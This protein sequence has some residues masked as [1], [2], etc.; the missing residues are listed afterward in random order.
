MLCGLTNALMNSKRRSPHW[1]WS[2]HHEHVQQSLALLC[3]QVVLGMKLE[4]LD[5]VGRE[6]LTAAELLE[7]WAQAAL[8]PDHDVLVSRHGCAA[9]CYI[10]YLYIL[11]NLQCS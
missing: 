8:L 6:Q 2:F 9:A 10:C 3:I 1:G 4:Y 5:A 7:F 11:G